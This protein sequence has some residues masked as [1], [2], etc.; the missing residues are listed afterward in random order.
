MFNLRVENATEPSQR[1]VLNELLAGGFSYTPDGEQIDVE[2]FEFE[3]GLGEYGVIRDELLT[4]KQNE[5]MEQE[6]AGYKDVYDA[7]PRNVN[8]GDDITV[9]I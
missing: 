5:I 6:N 1:A 8:D 7:L 3:L 9:S 4:R 2:T